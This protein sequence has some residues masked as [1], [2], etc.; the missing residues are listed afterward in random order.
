MIIPFIQN[1]SS[2]QQVFNIKSS[3]KSIFKHQFKT[4]IFTRF[5]LI[6]YLV[7]QVSLNKKEIE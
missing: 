4:D 6:H 7:I 5:T 3:F 1:C 2:A